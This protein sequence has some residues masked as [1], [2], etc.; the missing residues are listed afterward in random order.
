VVLRPSTAISLTPALKRRW[1]TS[2]RHRIFRGMGMCNEVKMQGSL[3][4]VVARGRCF[5][6]TLEEYRWS[7]YR[8][9]NIKQQFILPTSRTHVPYTLNA[10]VIDKHLVAST[11]AIDMGQP[12]TQQG[13]RALSCVHQRLCSIKKCILERGNKY[14]LLFVAQTVI[15]HNVWSTIQ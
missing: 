1:S 12:R 5:S 11:A 13:R 14:L 9:G 3:M 8:V 2:H 6:S 7:N 15:L 10:K 4:V